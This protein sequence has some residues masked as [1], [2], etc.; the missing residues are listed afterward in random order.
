MREKEMGLKEKRGA[1]SSFAVIGEA[2]TRRDSGA[3]EVG[4]R[5]A[6]LLTEKKRG[7]KEGEDGREI[8][9]QCCVVVPAWE[10]GRGG[11]EG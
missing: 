11:R 2:Q 6:T 4:R 3:A 9:R 1:G 10:G 5:L 7:E 8:E